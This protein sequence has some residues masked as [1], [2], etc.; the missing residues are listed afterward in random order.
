MD[1]KKT[2]EERARER[3]WFM[4]G[5]PCPEEGIHRLRG[6]L[7]TKNGKRRRTGYQEPAI[8]EG[9]MVLDSSE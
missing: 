9:F 5:T 6:I 3:L 4:T 7:R 2:E 1:R 8:M